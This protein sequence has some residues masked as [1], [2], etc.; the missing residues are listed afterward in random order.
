MWSDL[1]KRWRRLRICDPAADVVA[2]TTELMLVHWKKT[3]W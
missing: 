1:P 2:S 3:Y